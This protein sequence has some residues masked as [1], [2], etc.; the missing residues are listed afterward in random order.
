M[1][2]AEVDIDP[3]EENNFRIKTYNYFTFNTFKA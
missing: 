2:Y 1:N 3:N